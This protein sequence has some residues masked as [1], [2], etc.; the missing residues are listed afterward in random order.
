[1]SPKTIFAILLFAFSSSFILAQEPESV[2]TAPDTWQSEIIPFPIG[3]AREIEYKGFEELR[4]SP[5]WSDTTSQEF[6]AYMFVW[7]IEQDE[8][9]T[10]QK[11]TASFNLY[12]DGLMNIDLNNRNDSTG[13]NQL[14]KTICLFIKT[15]EGFSGKMRVFDRFFTKE[16]IVLNIKV[17]ETFCPKMNK[18]IISCEISPQA[19]D[20]EV[21][22]IFDQV[23]LK[24][25]CE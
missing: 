24:A 12:Y 25:N 9:L 2:L 10:E 16:Y 22:D 11:L 13:L 3:F 4:F 19:F 7:Y 20:H 18:Q 5:G 23:K 17:R 21:W 6:W 8:P 14:D 15:E 1:M